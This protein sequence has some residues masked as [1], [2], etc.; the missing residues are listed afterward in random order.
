M[1]TVIVLPS[2]RMVPGCRGSGALMLVPATLGSSLG[3][4]WWMGDAIRGP[5]VEFCSLTEAIDVGHD[6]GI[7]RKGA[8]VAPAAAGRRCDFQSFM[9]LI[10][11]RYV[12]Q[13]RYGLRSWFGLGS[14]TPCEILFGRR[15]CSRPGFSSRCSAGFDSRKELGN[16]ANPLAVGVHAWRGLPPTSAW[17]PVVL[18]GA[19]LRSVP[20]VVA[21]TP[22]VVRRARCW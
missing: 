6:S 16:H 8:G 3:G 12:T 13:C 4:A 5:G 17:G 9:A 1:R 22:A 7:S 18:A 15:L 14:R 11:G 21:G 2:L 20:R 10:L 19:R